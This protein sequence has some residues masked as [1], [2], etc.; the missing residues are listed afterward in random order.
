MDAFLTWLQARALPAAWAAR[1]PGEDGAAT[2]TTSMDRADRN[3][4]SRSGYRSAYR[5]NVA[6]LAR[7]QKPARGT[8]AYSRLVNRPLARRVAAAAH[9]V[10]MTPN[11]ATA[12]SAMLSATG[13]VLLAAVPPS[14]LLGAC[15][16]ALLAAGYVMDSVDGQLARLG[17]GGSVA[18][19]WLDHTVDCAKTAAFHLA[20]LIAWYRFP[21]VDATAALLVP[22]AFLV[23]DIVCFFGLVTMPLLRRLH[24]GRPATAPTAPEHP[25]RP[26]L[27]L[28]TDYGVFC[29]VFVLAGVP[30]AFFAAYSL[31]LAIN[32]VVLVLALRKW[33]RELEEVDRGAASPPGRH[34]LSESEGI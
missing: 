7:A 28:P 24:G 33:W 1:S 17:G 4:A 12:I 23:V 32:A 10:G 8:A 9:V 29:W 19:E 6:A 16:A 34:R 18:G 20:V 31:L 3:D 22:V 25:A 15:V 21:P 27:L 26:W 14:L 30:A 11:T 5:E 2:L 13:L